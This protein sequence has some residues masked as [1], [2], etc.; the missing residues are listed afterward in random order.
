MSFL[1]D[2]CAI[3][4]MSK[5]EP[6]AGFVQW[7]DTCDDD[8]LNICSVTLGEL[9]YG[10]DILPAGRRKNKLL[11]WYEMICLS[12]SGHIIEVSQMAF[13]RWGAL[14]ASR[15]SAGCILPM[16]DGLIAAVAT[17]NGMTVVTRNTDDFLDLGVDLINP[18]S[19]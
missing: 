12:Y 13:V 6:D 18:W 9:R 2:T 7:L 1:L 10:I 14:R 16:A 15:K 5:P 4:E 19:R 11:T 3:S 17:V 8:M